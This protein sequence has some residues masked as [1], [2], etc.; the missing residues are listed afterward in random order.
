MENKDFLQYKKASDHFSES[1]Y[2]AKLTFRKKSP[3]QNQKS[4][5]KTKK[6]SVKKVVN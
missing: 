1:P 4:Q 3:Y 5:L 6:R 2:L